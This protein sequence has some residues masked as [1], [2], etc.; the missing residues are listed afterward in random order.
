ME[1]RVVVALVLLVVGLV[2]SA[3][4]VWLGPRLNRGDD[5]E[6]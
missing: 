2:A 3:F 5:D 6:L 1:A 4:M